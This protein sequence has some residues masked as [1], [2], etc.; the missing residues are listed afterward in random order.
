MTVP[1]PRF[2]CRVRFRVTPRT[3]KTRPNGLVISF[4]PRYAVMITFSSAHHM[5]RS[6]PPPH[7]SPFPHTGLLW[8]PVAR[9]SPTPTFFPLVSFLVLY[10]LI[11]KTVSVAGGVS[12]SPN[13]LSRTDITDAFDYRPRSINF[14]PPW[15]AFIRPK[16]FFSSASPTPGPV[17]VSSCVYKAFPPDVREW[18]A[19][20]LT[21]FQMIA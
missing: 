21:I 6:R 4:R 18:D 17:R 8:R 2:F 1:S 20:R 19:P 12:D 11:F 14:T 15:L 13:F 7:I 16:F 3:P 9:T 5:A 10:R